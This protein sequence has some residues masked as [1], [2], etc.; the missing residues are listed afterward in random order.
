MTDAPHSAGGLGLVWPEY[1]SRSLADVLPA[2]ITALAGGPPDPLGLS[3]G[4]LHGVRAV[5]VLLVDGLGRG[6]IDRAGAAA[7]TLSG[8]AADP[9]SGVSF[10]TITA[11][12]PST[13]PTSLTSLGTGAAPGAHGVLG[14]TINIP[15]TERVLTHIDWDDDPEPRWWQPLPTQFDRAAASGIAAYVVNRP[16]F[17]RTGLT[18]A[19]YRGA[20][21]IGAT[22]VDGIADAMLAVLASATGPTLV[23]GYHADLDRTGHLHGVDS[24]QWTAAVAE[25]DRLITRV[26]AG[27]PAGTA[28]V[29]TADHGQLDVPAD[30]RFDLDTDPVLR[31]GVRV[32]A[33]E[34]RVRYLHTVEGA[35]A[36]VIAAWQATLGDIGW[37]VPRDE[38]VARGWFGPVPEGHLRRIGDVVAVCGGDY[39]VLATATEPARVANLIGFHG[40]ATEAEMLI[41]LLVVPAG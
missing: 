2:V 20:P 38:A 1:G 11:G 23:Y 34:P 40:S 5:A 30:H 28:L 37:V 15:G 12:F 25:V 16:E 3:V 26:V 36:D 19:A 17:A 4:P 18:Q 22:G 6:L 35:A 14:F 29:V 8:F 21:T 41:P 10:T 24:P 13:T 39:A 32:V 9:P 27:L 7:P 31:A 33:G